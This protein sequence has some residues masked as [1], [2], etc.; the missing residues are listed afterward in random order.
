MA[1]ENL[2][3]KTDRFDGHENYDLILY[4]GFFSESGNSKK[5]HC[6][7][8]LKSKLRRNTE[9]PRVKGVAKNP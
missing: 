2:L 4:F 8:L 6:F 9:I 7:Q 1:S 5:S 3:M